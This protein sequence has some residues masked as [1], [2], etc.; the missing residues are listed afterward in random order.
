MVHGRLCS[1]VV[2]NG[3]IWESSYQFYTKKIQ[4]AGRNYAED[5]GM[6]PMPIASETVGILFICFC[7]ILI[8]IFLICNNEIFSSRLY[9]PS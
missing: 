3:I 1:N 9:F 7:W 2:E 4:V 5:D 8:V 6:G